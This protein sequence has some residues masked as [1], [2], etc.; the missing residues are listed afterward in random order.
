MKFYDNQRVETPEGS[1]TV[2]YGGKIYQ[3]DGNGSMRRVEYIWLD[4]QKKMA[5]S[6]LNGKTVHL[7]RQDRE[8]ICLEMQ[9]IVAEMEAKAKILVESALT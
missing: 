9:A 5:V 6:M 3:I 8:I 4:H 1:L 2:T 7:Q